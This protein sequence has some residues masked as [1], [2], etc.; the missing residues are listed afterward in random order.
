LDLFI[1]PSPPLRV[2]AV[3]GRGG[4]ASPGNSCYNF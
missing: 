3:R 4:L 1:L 2:K